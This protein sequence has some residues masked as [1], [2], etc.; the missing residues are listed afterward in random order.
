MIIPQGKEAL[1]AQGCSF[2]QQRPCS[3]LGS[4]SQ[5]SHLPRC[6]RRQRKCWSKAERSP[7]KQSQGSSSHSL[8][9]CHPLHPGLNSP[10]G[11]QGVHMSGSTGSGAEKCRGAEKHSSPGGRGSVSS[12]PPPASSHVCFVSLSIIPLV[13]AEPPKHALFPSGTPGSRA[14]CAKGTFLHQQRRSCN[15][16]NAVYCPINPRSFCAGSPY[17]MLMLARC[18]G[19]PREPTP[20]D[21]LVFLHRSAAAASAHESQGRGWELQCPLG[22]RDAGGVYS[23]GPRGSEGCPGI[24]SQRRCDHTLRLT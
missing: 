3:A 21:R 10:G 14:S 24:V 8:F 2:G 5:V 9:P 23:P 4:K 22:P 17:A 7:S 12:V 6:H 18:A 11:G 1:G 19:Q 16:N 13:T 15:A 20:R